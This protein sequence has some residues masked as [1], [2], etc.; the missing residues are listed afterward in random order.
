MKA[1]GLLRHRFWGEY[2]AHIILEFESREDAEKAKEILNNDIEF[3]D[4]LSAN[5]GL[6]ESSGW[7]LI[8]YRDKAKVE[9]MLSVE[10]AD[11]G[12]ARIIERLVKYGADE[13]KITSMAKSIDY[14]EPFTIEIP[15]ENKDQLVLDIPA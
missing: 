6:Y 5:G 12:L 11:P 15:Q 14:G 10:A 13:K 8:P 4:F 3:G 9:C 7:G 1:K 2:S